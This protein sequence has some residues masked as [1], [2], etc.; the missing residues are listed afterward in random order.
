[1]PFEDRRVDYYQLPI[2]REDIHFLASWKDLARHEEELL[3]VGGWLWGLCPHQDP[4]GL[5]LH[6]IPPQT[7]PQSKAPIPAHSEDSGP[8]A[9]ASGTCPQAF[10]AAP[11]PRST[12]HLHCGWSSPLCRPTGNQGPGP[13]PV[14]YKPTGLVRPPQQRLPPLDFTL[15]GP[16]GPW[17]WPQPCGALG[18]PP[19]L[20]PALYSPAG[21]SVWTWSGDPRL[22]Q[23]AGPRHPSCKWRWRAVCSC[24]TC[25]CSH[26]QQEGKCPRPS[27][28]WCPSC[29][30]TP[31][32]LSWVSKAPAHPGGGCWGEAR[33][34]S[35]SACHADGPPCRLWDGRGPSEPGC[36]LP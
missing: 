4:P 25:L 36:F 18:G 15:R 27:P 13:A 26:G 35:S 19:L 12:A 22:A 2:A 7:P 1:M 20:I 32:S 6:P 14:L 29:S 16:G 31:P 10:G 21:W 8:K 3:R 5:T 17:P 11:P 34:P 24:W 30:R 33:A 23:G 28:G 9:Q